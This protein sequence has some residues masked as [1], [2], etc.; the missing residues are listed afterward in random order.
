MSLIY[1]RRIF[2]RS[3]KMNEEKV[4]I[5]LRKLYLKEVGQYRDEKLLNNEQEEHCPATPTRKC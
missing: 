4:V 3:C 1:R 2:D 5:I